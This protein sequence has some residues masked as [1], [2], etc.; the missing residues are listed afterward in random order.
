MMKVPDVEIIDPE[1]YWYVRIGPFASR[2][3]A[4]Q[5]MAAIRIL[6][7]EEPIEGKALNVHVTDTMDI[8]TEVNR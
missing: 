5:F 8:S 4:A 7:V 1:R 6:Q 3:E 2:L